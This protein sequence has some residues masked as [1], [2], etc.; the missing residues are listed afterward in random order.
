MGL[1]I[2]N[3]LA[4]GIVP[5][6]L[7][8]LAHYYTL[9]FLLI[10]AALATINVEIDEAD[11][12][13]EWGAELMRDGRHQRLALL[14]DRAAVVSD[15]RTL[16]P[17]DQRSHDEGGDEEPKI[18]RSE[19]GTPHVQHRHGQ[20]DGGGTV[21]GQHGPPRRAPVGILSLAH[22]EEQRQSGQHEPYPLL[23]WGFVVLSANTRLDEKMRHD[24][25]VLAIQAFLDD[26]TMVDFDWEE[27]TGRLTAQGEPAMLGSFVGQTFRAEIESTEGPGR[28]DFLVTEAQLKLA[29]Q[30]TSS[31][32]TA[33]A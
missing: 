19:F 5:V 3:W 14:L 25:L 32:P 22:G 15:R 17:D 11:D 10:S 1:D 28:V 7:T 9:G 4:W 29:A 20:H 12:G 13:G 18:C 2:P 26:E 16:A 21:R 24:L 27:A 33:M 8:L 23:R 30:A 6:S 31:D